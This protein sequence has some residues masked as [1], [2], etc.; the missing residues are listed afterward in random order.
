M[1]LWVTIVYNVTNHGSIVTL[2]WLIDH[3]RGLCY[4]SILIERR[5]LV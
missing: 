1:R 3:Y 5:L 4:N 2:L